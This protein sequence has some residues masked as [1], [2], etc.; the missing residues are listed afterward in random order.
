MRAETPSPRDH[1]YERYCRALEHEPLPLAI[2]DLDA[3]DH[4]LEALL[5]SA[6]A[7]GKTL[8]IASKS[9]RCPDLLRYLLDRG[10]GALR[11]L[12]AYSCAEARFLASRGFDDLLIAYPTAQP[13]DARLV[14]E[15]NP[16]GA[17]VS[18]A[19]DCTTHLA[20]AS[21]AAVELGATIPVILDVDVSYRAL[22]GREHVGMR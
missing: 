22:G 4:N 1:R 21:R 2:V 19:V 12:M 8:R 11:G 6:R 18:L 7:G 9:V 15:A 17:R 14:A 16:Q 5:A 13:S 20:V 10:R 3:L